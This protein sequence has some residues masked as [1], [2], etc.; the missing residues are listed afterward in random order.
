M[1]ARRRILLISI[2]IM[3]GVAVGVG[4]VAVFGLY[5]TS[6]NQQRERLVETVRSR[7]QLIDAVARHNAVNNPDYPG[8]FAAATLDEVTKAHAQ[9]EGFGDTGEF[10][11]ARRDGDMIEFLLR[12][13]HSDV[14]NPEPIPF[15]SKLAE[16]MRRALSGRSGTV[17]GLD[18]RGELVLAAYEQIEPVKWG[19]VAKIDL[20]EIRS[21][22]IRTGM[23]VALVGFV[24]ISIGA[25]LLLRHTDPLIGQLET[26]QAH[27]RAMLETAADGI[28]T[29]NEHGVVQSCNVAAERMFGHAAKDMIGQSVVMLVRLPH[30]TRPEELLAGLGEAGDADRAW[31]FEGRRRDGTAF[32]LEVAFSR[33]GLRDQTFFMGVFRDLGQRKRAERSLWFAQFVTDHAGDAIFWVDPDGHFVYVNQKACESLGYSRQELLRMIVSDIDP[34]YPAAV[35]PDVWDEIKRRRSFTLEGHHRTKEG[36][37]FPVEITANYLQFNGKEYNCSFARD[38]TERKHVEERLRAAELRYRTLF[39]QS[40]DAILLIDPKTTRPVEFNDCALQVFG[41]TREALA[42]SPI[43]DYEAKERP[44]ETRAHIEGILRRGRDAFETKI[45]T[46]SGQ[47]RD[48]RVNV[49]TV[50]LSGQVYLHSVIRDVTERKQAEE[51]LRLNE[52]RLE[53][54]VRLNE[55]TEASF[56]QIADFA[57]QEAVQLT[58]SE[59]GSLGLLNDDESELTVRTWST[60][61]TETSVV[62]DEPRVVRVV[63]AG[64][65]GE[66]VRQRRPV[67]VND[68]ARVQG[69]G[70]GF[71]DDGGVVSRFLGVPLFDAD[72]V[73]AVIAVANKGAEYQESDVRHLSLLGGGMWR[74]VQRQRTERALRESREF[75]Q[76]V[77]DAIPESLMVIDRDHGVVL[78]NQAVR[79][80]AG[81][82]DQVLRGL[83][84][85]Q[86]L[87]CRDTACGGAGS[88]CPLDNVIATNAPV[89]VMHSHRDAE[90]NERLMEIVAV[91]VVGAA[92]DVVRVIESGRDVTARVTAE[93]QARQRRVELSHVLRLDT[94]GEMASGL[95]HEL[96]QPLAAIVNYLQACLMRASAG[97]GDFDE[98]FADVRQA[99][100]QANRAAQIIERIRNLARKGHS[101]HI[102]L[103]VNVAVQE[104]MDL[105]RGEIRQYK[106]ELSLELAGSLPPVCGDSVEIQQVVLNLVR[107]ALEAMSQQPSSSRRLTVRTRSLVDSV[108]VEV[109]DSGPGVHV[110]AEEQMFVPFF[111]TKRDGLGMGLSLSRTIIEAHGGRLW[112][113]PDGERGMTLRFTLPR[114]HKV[115][116]DDR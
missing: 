70:H 9:F 87:H 2:I 48:V 14:D 52:A 21:V 15:D 99:I 98:M 115:P 103:D 108:E 58:S 32:P 30:D 114:R 36:R 1:N 84:C 39:E 95:A 77:I 85:H 104:V 5:E 45:R 55:M 106:V 78:A 4:A 11:L 47:L 86:C 8:G 23:L 105:L 40:P 13:R 29:L 63:E 112:A 83:K 64:L 113:A 3:T 44:E 18:Y 74:L 97:R 71:P 116:D 34:D 89:T 38:V 54:L 101:K 41:R 109:E 94:M 12:H 66:V 61:T 42:S 93:N 96:N 60:G 76:S 37:L 62:D 28:L 33:V 27:T 102:L 72:R 67:I 6:V 35:W 49:R 100:A 50:E 31:E 88:P 17:V 53:S 59:T 110:G 91:P 111:T 16:P 43:A 73:V 7:A 79:A 65:L 92:G 56:A 57:V 69:A 25:V 51:A 19:V 68:G 22:F 81:G 10:T 107:N 80:M 90:G 75:L 24:V 20:A 26:S 46:G 82:G